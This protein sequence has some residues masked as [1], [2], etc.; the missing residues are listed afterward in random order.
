MLEM[1]KKCHVCK[2]EITP[3]EEYN[4]HELYGF[5]HVDCVHAKGCVVAKELDVKKF[6]KSAQA[7]EL[8]EEERQ[9]LKEEN[10]IDEF[11]D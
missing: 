8:N 4:F 1:N 11:E 9:R 2:K 7:T 10:T 6:E 3:D 5:S